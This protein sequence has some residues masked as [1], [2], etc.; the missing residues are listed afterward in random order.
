MVDSCQHHERRPSVR[1]R[2][3]TG[4]VLQGRIRHVTCAWLKSMA[5]AMVA[6]PVTVASWRVGAS[7]EH[8]QAQA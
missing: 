3:G 1:R 8:L 4:K 2:A 5:E 7:V 6:V